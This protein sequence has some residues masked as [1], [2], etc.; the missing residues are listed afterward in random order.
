MTSPA[1]P[2][3]LLI[4]DDPAVARFLQHTLTA[5]GYRIAMAER[6]KEG[7]HLASQQVP[8]LILLDLGLPDIDGIEVLR[9]LRTW[10][11][12]PVVIL[13]ARDQESQKVDALDAGADDYL[14]KPV[15]L[16]E[17]LARLRVALR[18]GSRLATGVI[19]N[20]HTLGPLRIDLTRR[21][22]WVDDLEVHLSPIEY[23][24]L[25]ALIEADGTVVTHSKLLRAVW[26]PHSERHR[27]YLRVYMA[28]LRR[29]LKLDPTHAPLI[30]TETGVGY[31]IVT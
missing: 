18:H 14:T 4:E 25:I 10:T 13:S 2:L 11:R 1:G 19:P 22:L 20:E 8:D 23:K 6:G 21:Q 31:R 7:L 30:A 15:G 29:K 28:H 3:I 12:L 16:A 27:E 5:N 9:Q 26:G 24:L 17:L